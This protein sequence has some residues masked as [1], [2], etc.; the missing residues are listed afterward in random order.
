V[1]D[2]R[3]WAVIQYAE[4]QH[5]KFTD[6]SMSVPESVV[7]AAAEMTDRTMTKDFRDPATVAELLLH[8]VYLYESG[9]YEASHVAAW[10]IA[11]KCLHERWETHLRELNSQHTVPGSEEKFI[12]SERKQKLTGRDFTASLIL[13]ALSLFGLLPFDKYKLAS[14]VRQAR[15]DWLHKLHTIDRMDAAE[16]ILLAGSMLRDIRVLDVEIPFHLVT[17]IPIAFVSD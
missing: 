2:C 11:E 8:S 15:N 12:N 10:T 9:K 14:R 1:C 16:A 13:E 7:R 6:A 5:L 4:E 17:S 3:Q